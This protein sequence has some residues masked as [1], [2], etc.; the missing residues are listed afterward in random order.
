MRNLVVG[1]RGLSTGGKFDTT[2]SPVLSVNPDLPKLDIF[3]ET[4]KEATDEGLFKEGYT[5]KGRLR[6]KAKG[7][8]QQLFLQFPGMYMCPSEKVLLTGTEY[9]RKKHP[10]EFFT[11]GRV[12]SKVYTIFTVSHRPRFL[13]HFGQRY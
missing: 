11:D 1:V 2:T 7:P 8:Y 6:G 5:A 3:V 12:S 9:K 10:K 4:P 13:R